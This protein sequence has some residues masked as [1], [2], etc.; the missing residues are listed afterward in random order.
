MYELVVLPILIISL[1][2]VA[3]RP[4]YP[5]L[6]STYTTLFPEHNLEEHSSR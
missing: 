4:I 2:L 3:L 5:V 6:D 1:R